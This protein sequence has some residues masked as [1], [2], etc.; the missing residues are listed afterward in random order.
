MWPCLFCV[1]FIQYFICTRVILVYSNNMDAANAISF[2]TICCMYFTFQ[3]TLFGSIND[4]HTDYFTACWM[5]MYAHAHSLHIHL[6][7]F[8]GRLLFFGRMPRR[9]ST[10]H[11]VSFFLSYLSRAHMKRSLSMPYYYFDSRRATVQ[12]IDTKIG[13]ESHQLRRGMAIV[14]N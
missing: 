12:N 5:P 2:D 3:L 10:L 13:T 7:S 11:I 9:A 8:W 14:F 1:P 4:L 6:L